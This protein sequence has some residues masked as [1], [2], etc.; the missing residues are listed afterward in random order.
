METIVPTS[1]LG[2]YEMLGEFVKLIGVE[3]R[4]KFGE[5]IF[6]TDVET[7]EYLTENQIMN[8]GDHENLPTRRKKDLAKKLK[9]WRTLIYPSFYLTQIMRR[10][11][12]LNQVMSKIAYMKHLPK[13]NCIKIAIQFT[14]ELLGSYNLSHQ[15]DKLNTCNE[16]IAQAI[17]QSG[18]H[19]CTP[20]E[21]KKIC[22]FLKNAQQ[23]REMAAL[24]RI[25]KINR[26]QYL[27]CIKAGFSFINFMKMT[28]QL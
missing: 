25:Y 1:L 5:Y 18:W 20:Q 7:G 22:V 8:N 10:Y 2:Q 14:C 19:N 13:Y 9:Q 26:R 15:A 17:Y 4:N 24:G 23:E 27:I 28:G 3:H 21:R 6:Y 16:I 12:G 11:Q